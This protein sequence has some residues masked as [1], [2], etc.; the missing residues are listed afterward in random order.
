M[1]AN[2]APVKLAPPILTPNRIQAAIDLL[3]FGFMDDKTPILTRIAS[4]GKKHG[5]GVAGIKMGGMTVFFAFSASAIHEALLDEHYCFLKG[6]MAD[7]RVRNIFD[8]GGFFN[9]ERNPIP[10]KNGSA[11]LRKAASPHMQPAAH[12]KSE[13]FM[14]ELFERHIAQW[15]KSDSIDIGLTTQ[16]MVLELNSRFIF[17]DP[18]DGVRQQVPVLLKL[19]TSLLPLRSMPPWKGQYEYAKKTVAAGIRQAADLEKKNTDPKKRLTLLRSLMDLNIQLTPQEKDELGLSQDLLTGNGVTLMAA[20]SD[21]LSTLIS[22][23]IMY[24]L[25]MPKVYSGIMTEFA[26]FKDHLPTYMEVKTNCPYFWGFVKEVERLRPP[27]QLLFRQVGPEGGFLDG[28][29]LEPNSFLLLSQQYTHVDPAYFP[30]PLSIKPERWMTTTPPNAKAFFPF[31]GG[32]RICIGAGEVDVILANFFPRLLR[33]QLTAKSKFDLVKLYFSGTLS[34]PP[35]S[36]V[37]IRHRMG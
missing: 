8:K 10:T 18:L 17:N 4:E 7:K 27:A 21:T 16:D 15:M 6:E 35:H 36:M 2:Q 12:I 26:Q 34:A 19:G 31:G 20:S 5:S 37:N 32:P 13:E 9:V 24:M 14:G 1:S 22:Y 25:T 23:M 3:A 11:V 30:D 29:W 33:Y 28:Y